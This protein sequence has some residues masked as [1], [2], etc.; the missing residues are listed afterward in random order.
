MAAGKRAQARSG[1]RTKVV[2][3][4]S[5]SHR[6]ARSSSRGGRARRD[7][8]HRGAEVRRPV[9]ARGREEL[10]AIRTFETA[11]RFFRKGNYRRAVE[12]FQKLVSCSLPEF[13]DRARIH[14]RLCEQRLGRGA[15]SPRTAEEQY[16]CGITA[17][18]RRD[19]DAAVEYL[20][21]ADK[22]KPKRQH[23][24][25]ALAAVYSLQGNTDLALKFLESAIALRSQNRAQARHDDDFQNLAAEPRF[26]QLLEA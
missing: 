1:S 18:N 25:Y 8:G 3:K 23:V 11:I 12:G 24:R 21:K 13:A 20:Q 6:S 17:L 7:L 4:R 5:T 10:V 9:P 26:Q 22:L 16:L 14:L 2:R 15:A 19:F